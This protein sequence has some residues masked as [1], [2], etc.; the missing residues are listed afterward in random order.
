MSE[1]NKNRDENRDGKRGGEFRVPPRTIL[2]WIAIMGAI[3]L[4]M[5]MNKGVGPSQIEPLKQSQLMEK[6]NSNQIAQ[7]TITYDPQS[8]LHDV[9]GSYFKTDP[10]GERVLEDGKPIKVP[11]YAKVRLTEKMEDKILELGVF[12]TR[13]PNTVLLGLA[14]SLG[15]IL[16]IGVLIWFFFIRQIKMAGKGALSF[17]KSKA[18]MLNKEKNKTTFKDVAGVEE[19]K[20]EVSELVEFLKDPKKFQKLGGRIPKGI[21]MIGSPGTGKTLLAKAIAGEADASF[22]SISGSDFVEMFAPKAVGR[23]RDRAHTPGPRGS[24]YRSG[25]P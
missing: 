10:A 25:T 8:F 7:G 21:L 9:R 19:A 3:P 12:E 2:I 17:G 23:G 4:L 22:F 13:Q 1:E 18:R 20:D 24:T 14:Y 16:V 15:P 6:V 11:F 5:F